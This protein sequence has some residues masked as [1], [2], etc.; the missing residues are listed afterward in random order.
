MELSWEIKDRCKE[1]LAYD[2]IGLMYFHLGELDKAN[3]YHE[4]MNGGKYEHEESAIRVRSSN[5]L[6]IRRKKKH[7]ISTQDLLLRNR[8][9]SVRLS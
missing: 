4:R 5:D 1:L 9:A 3:S 2:K 8:P 6:R 7:D